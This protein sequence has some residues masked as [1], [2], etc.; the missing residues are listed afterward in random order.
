MMNAKKRAYYYGQI[1]EWIACLYLLL[2]GYR[3]LQ[4]NYLTKLGQI[5]LIMMKKDALVFVEVKSRKNAEM[6]E[7]L[8]SKQQKRH[9][10]HAANYFIT[11]NKKFSNKIIRFDAIYIVGL[12]RVM[13]FKNIYDEL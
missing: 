5:D 1:S 13:H 2:K 12:F 7:N 10:W 8:I 11:K 3:F 4:H 6:L 9:L